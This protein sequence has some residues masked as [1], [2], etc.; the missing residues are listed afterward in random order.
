MI[1]I[2]ALAFSVALVAQGTAS[3]AVAQTILAPQS[4]S[5]P[6]VASHKANAIRHGAR[7]LYNMAPGNYPA[8]GG[9]DDPAVTGGGSIGYNQMIY[10]W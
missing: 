3:S 4:A 5:P 6:S 10:N 9:S 7:P 8:R 2:S 1:R